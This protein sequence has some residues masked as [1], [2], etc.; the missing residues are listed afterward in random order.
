MTLT[1]E[2][3]PALAARIH[4]AA[5]RA[6]VGTADF[7]QATLEK[8]L[9]REPARKTK[10]PPCLSAAE[11]ELLLKINR[12]FD[13]Q[14]WERYDELK[15]KRRAESLTAQAHAELVALTNQQEA[16]NLERVQAL[17]ELARLR[18]V[19]LREVM[20]QLGINPP[21]YE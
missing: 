7:I 4:L 16:L 13:E 20:Q 11:T 18:K 1:I 21:P 15:A 2:L 5:A 12:G 14:T 17:A 6:G 3:K 8:N 10:L 19:G 9:P